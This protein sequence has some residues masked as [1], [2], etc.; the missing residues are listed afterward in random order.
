[1]ALSSCNGTPLVNG[2]GSTFTKGEL[3]VI[4]D[5]CLEVGLEGLSVEIG[6]GLY[7]EE[8]SWSITFPSGRVEIGDGDSPF[9]SG[10]CIS[11]YPTTQ[12]SVSPM[13]TSLP[14]V[15]PMP[16]APCEVYTIELSDSYGDG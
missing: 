7:P 14:S 15:T 8:A 11:P 2:I 5:I 9:R 1:M 3:R 16:T 4:D 13:P 12:P 10:S 6:G